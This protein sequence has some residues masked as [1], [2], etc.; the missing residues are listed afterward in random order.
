MFI[1]V[2][3]AFVLLFDNDLPLSGIFKLNGYALRSLSVGGSPSSFLNINAISLAN[4]ALYLLES[5]SSSVSNIK[6]IWG[7]DFPIYVIKSMDN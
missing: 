2:S 3:M 6:I 1:S 5:F 4:G 7:N